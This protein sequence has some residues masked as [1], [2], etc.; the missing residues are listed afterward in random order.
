MILTQFYLDIFF[1][2]YLFFYQFQDIIQTL[3]NINIKYGIPRKLFQIP[4]Y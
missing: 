1:F 2:E 3:I 4:F